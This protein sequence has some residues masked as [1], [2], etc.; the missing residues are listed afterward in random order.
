MRHFASENVALRVS[1]TARHD[2]AVRRLLGLRVWRAG[3]ILVLASPAGAVD[4]VRDVDQIPVGITNGEPAQ[5]PGLRFEF[6]DDL[7]TRHSIPLV[8]GVRVIDKHGE[9]RRRG[10]LARER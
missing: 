1:L 3:Q 8:R 2:R 10:S 6:V 5:T 4:F 7:G 9:P